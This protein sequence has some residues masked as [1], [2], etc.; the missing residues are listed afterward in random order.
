MLTWILTAICYLVV[1][2]R[3]ENVTINTIQLYI[4]NLFK[5]EGSKNLAYLPIRPVARRFCPNQ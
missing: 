1:C 4:R 2:L 3:Q 5:A